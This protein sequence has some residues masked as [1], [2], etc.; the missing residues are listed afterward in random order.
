MGDRGGGRGGRES[1]DEMRCTDS[2][3]NCE[4]IKDELVARVPELIFTR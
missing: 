2:K 1:G 3:L 4:S